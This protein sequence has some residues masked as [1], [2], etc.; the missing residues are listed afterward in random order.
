MGGNLIRNSTATHV[1]Q[2]GPV[3][4][5]HL[6]ERVRATGFTDDMLLL[7]APAR[8]VRG[9]LR[10]GVDRLAGADPGL[11]QLRTAAQSVLG[12]VVAVG[13]V[14]VFVQLTGAL[15]KSTGPTAVVTA[16]NHATLIV[17]MLI[18]GMIAM[19]AGFVATDAT[20]RGQVVTTLILPLPMLLSISCALALGRFRVV[21]LVFLVALLAVSVYVRRWGPRGTACGLVAFNGGFLGFFLHSELSVR[22]V[23]WL[24]GDLAIG[25]AAS[26][27]VRLTLLRP[28]PARTLLRMRR[29]WDARVDRLLT[30]GV[31]ALQAPDARHRAAR[32]L[33]LRRQLVRLNEST[34]MID[35]QLVTAHPHAGAT[36]AQALFDAEL[37]L[38]NCARFTGAIADVSVD[39]HLREL[40]AVALSALQAGDD[41][42]VQS[43]VVRLRTFVTG[44]ER[45]QVLARRLGASVADY[46]EAR[47]RLRAAVTALDAV[48]T[49]S[50]PVRGD[51]AADY[52]EAAHNDEADDY[53]AAVALNAGYLPGSMN[54]STAASTI[55]GRGGF[56]D[57]A[58][59]PPY[60]RAAIQIA[61]AGTLAIVIGDLVSGQRLYWAVISTFLA[62]MATTNS[63]E[64]VRKALFRVAGT[65][66][67]IVLGDLLVHLTGGYLWS[68]LVIV[69]LALFFGIYLIRVNY[70]FMVIGITVT[71]SQLYK[72][73]GEFSW[74]LMVLRL[75]E[76]AI[77]VGC[78]VVTVSVIFP[79]RPQRV[80]TTGVLLWFRALDEVTDL[81]L[82]K[83]VD[84]RPRELRAAV[85]RLDA[86]FAALEAT[87]APLRG[88]TFGRNSAQLA[89]IRSV[90]AAARSY[91]RSLAAAAQAV[92]VPGL[93]ALRAVSEQ[94]R[95]SNTAIA[96]R[97][98]GGT[99]GAFVRSAA[100]VERARHDVDQSVVA[101]R[102]ALRDLTMLDGALARLAAALGMDVRDHDTV[103]G[104]ASVPSG[105]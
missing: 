59:M 54:V 5:L 41:A 71:M 103:T 20:A 31:A 55:P 19:M 90:S 36:S 73:L 39:Q 74:H 56:L 66:L 28:E 10:D 61:V 24:A 94:M 43:T 37:A 53:V 92:Q 84:G 8:S 64:Q 88:T 12:I 99:N 57:R 50:G 40:A 13:A 58:A 62:F 16:Y 86:A 35:A 51:G 46:A 70:T 42:S 93:P 89:E 87:A 9:Y 1:H 48:P 102:P 30:L 72:Q 34:L 95:S 27:L 98:E 65:A 91:A 45:E 23:G 81:A 14:D 18:A 96:A 78:V 6:I 101:L 82:A 68:S 69:L 44:R 4:G 2:D 79:L 63:A 11:T 17:S 32:Q 105:S 7:A 49:G 38:A 100:L 29:S 85:R 76:T 15:Q 80:L 26:L 21:S 77:G 3:A 47:P 22:D 52:D 104:P 33:A 75:G 60:V 67:G 83:L 25:V 97:I